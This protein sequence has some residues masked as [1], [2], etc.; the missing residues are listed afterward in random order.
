MNHLVKILCLAFFVLFGACSLKQYPDPGL[1][2]GNSMKAE[3]QILKLNQDSTALVYINKINQKNS[4]PLTQS[5]MEGDKVDFLFSFGHDGRT[6]QDS[7]GEKYIYP[8]LSTEDKL[9]VT[10][11]VLPKLNSSEP[12]YKV[13]WY[14]KQ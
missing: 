13:V 7:D 14:K 5:L 8:K 3:V 6:F 4:D 9:T 10:L 11:V 1:S 12:L 2:G